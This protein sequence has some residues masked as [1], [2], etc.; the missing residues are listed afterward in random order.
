MSV[1][2]NKYQQTPPPPPPLC[3]RVGHVPVG[4]VRQQSSLSIF[5][6]RQWQ[7]QVGRPFMSWLAG[8]GHAAQYTRFSV[9]QNAANGLG[10]DATHELIIL[11]IS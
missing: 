11:I 2:P 4:A 6:H 5:Q 7:Q 10:Q 3:L 9:G 1:Q 8:N